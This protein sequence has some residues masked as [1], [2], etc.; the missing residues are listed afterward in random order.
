MAKSSAP[1][2]QDTHVFTA[3]SSEINLAALMTLAPVSGD[4]GVTKSGIVL[5]NHR[6][7]VR[8]MQNGKPV[9]YTVSV[10]VQR[11]AIN[12][13]EA[14]AVAETAEEREANAAKRKKED[15]DKRER[16]IR[17]ACEITESGVANGFKSALQLAA[18]NDAKLAAARALIGR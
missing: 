5:D 4:R 16:E 18:E 15:D 17:R 2:V 3:L 6:E 10:Y 1:I 9:T 11:D 12:D 13:D 14:K 8:V 7:T